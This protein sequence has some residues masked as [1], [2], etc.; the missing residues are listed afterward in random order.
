M[1]TCL[2]YKIIQFGGAQGLGLGIYMG[3]VCWCD[4][5]L[6]VCPECVLPAPD[7]A[8]HLPYPRRFLSGTVKP[9]GV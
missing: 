7:T 8:P 4:R 3:A 6:C 2:C 5:A 1:L 9:L